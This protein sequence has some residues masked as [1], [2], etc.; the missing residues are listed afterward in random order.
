MQVNKNAFIELELMINHFMHRHT[1]THIRIYIYISFCP[2]SL[3]ALDCKYAQL[4]KL[5]F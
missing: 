5:G 2:H 3:E 1:D 4:L